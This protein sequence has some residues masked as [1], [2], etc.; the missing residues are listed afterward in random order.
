MKILLFGLMDA[1][2]ISKW[3]SKMYKKKTGDII[4]DFRQDQYR[5]PPTFAA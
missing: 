2:W 4:K 5:I 1:L 3:G